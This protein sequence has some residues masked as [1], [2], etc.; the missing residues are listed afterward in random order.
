[1]TSDSLSLTCVLCCSDVSIA[2]A[3]WPSVVC[4]VSCVV[5]CVVR[6]RKGGRNFGF[7]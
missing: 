1:M 5:W 2:C 6:R 4:A 3:L 7:R